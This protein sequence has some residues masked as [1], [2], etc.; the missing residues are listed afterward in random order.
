MS[1]QKYSLARREA[2]DRYDAKTYKQINFRLR[3]EDDADIIK[4]IE[5]GQKKGLNNREWLRELFE[6]REK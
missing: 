2:N 5:E 1:K 3:Y 6:G 4:A